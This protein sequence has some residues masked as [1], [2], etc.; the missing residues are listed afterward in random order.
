MVPVVDI[1]LK[2][3]SVMDATLTRG[4]M[5]NLVK[6]PELCCKQ[7]GHTWNPLK[8]TPKVCPKCKSY[9][10]NVDKP[11]STIK[12]VMVSEE[13]ENALNIGKLLESHIDE[14]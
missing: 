1:N 10:W 8:P 2:N 5:I 7:C 11:K 14:G 3:H 4:D 13:P 6:I 12:H 9:K